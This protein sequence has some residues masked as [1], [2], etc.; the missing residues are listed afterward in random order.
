[1]GLLQCLASRLPR[2]ADRSA[3]AVASAWRLASRRREAASTAAKAALAR[4]W[5]S[6][7]IIA[8]NVL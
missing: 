5:R 4:P 6:R 1:V 2:N 8:V 3:I 7:S